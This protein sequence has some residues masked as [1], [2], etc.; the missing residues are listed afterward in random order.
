M[1]EA[2]LGPTWNLEYIYSQKSFSEGKRNQRRATSKTFQSLAATKIMNEV[3]FLVIN[4]LSTGKSSV[5]LGI[6]SM[7]FMILYVICLW[8]L[9]THI[10]DGGCLVIEAIKP[11]IRAYI[12]EM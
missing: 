1:D 3:S 10:A 5:A 6:I 8:T 4:A 2:G 12:E 11:G 7:S 9:G